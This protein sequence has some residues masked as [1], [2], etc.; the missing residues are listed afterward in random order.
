MVRLDK[1]CSEQRA[2]FDKCCSMV[3]LFWVTFVSPLVFN[4][5]QVMRMQRAV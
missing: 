2:S 4:F 1:A 3:K 5:I